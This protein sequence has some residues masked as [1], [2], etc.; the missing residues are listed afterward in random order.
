M[1]HAISPAF[2]LRTP[3]MAA[4]IQPL[5]G[6]A[7]AVF[8]GVE[9]D[10]FVRFGSSLQPTFVAPMVAENVPAFDAHDPKNVELY[11]N[12]MSKAQG[13]SQAVVSN[14]KVGV[15]LRGESGRA[16]LGT[17]IEIKG[18]NQW[19][20]V[21][22]EGFAVT[23]ARAFGEDKVTDLFLSGPPCGHCRQMLFE[24][25]NPDL[26]LHILDRASGNI[27][28]FTFGQLFPVP[29][30]STGAGAEKNVLKPSITPIKAGLRHRSPLVLSAMQGA[31]ESYL[32]KPGRKSWAGLAVQL[33]SGE[34]FNGGT[35]T[36]SGANPTI[37]PIQTVLVKL[38]AAGK[39]F[40]DI[41][42]AVLVEPRDPD[43]SSYQQT[44]AILKQVAPDARLQ[45][46]Q[47][48]NA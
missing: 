22:G 20:T 11:T 4:N 7:Q 46:V 30:D 9:T 28:S 17:N 27:Q 15:V 26:K 21:H 42:R 6:R 5:P 8:K 24:L 13:F 10:R 38:T 48:P 29:F 36:V 23:Q 18:D 12:L 31:A 43:Y 14:Y 35:I 47:L 39:A 3:R 45:K 2:G 40:A 1:L 16:Y 34:I 33:K 44:R 25:G 32:P 37:Q 19:N 41:A